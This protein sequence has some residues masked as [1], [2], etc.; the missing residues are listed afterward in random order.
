LFPLV[1]PELH[2]L[3]HH[4]MSRERAGPRKRGGD[5]GDIALLLQG[6]FSDIGHAISQISAALQ[7]KMGHR[8]PFR[9]AAALQR[10]LHPVGK[11]DCL[12]PRLSSSRLY[13]RVT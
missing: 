11:I 6:T 8:R 9:L 2:R 7:E 10:A 12:I 1:Q 3:A 4:Y 5:I 13:H